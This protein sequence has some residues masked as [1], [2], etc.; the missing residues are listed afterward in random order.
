MLLGH[1]V[2]IVTEIERQ[3]GQVEQAPRNRRPPCCRPYNGPVGPSTRTDEVQG[4]LI[5]AGGDRR[6][7]SKNTLLPDRLDGV[8]GS[9]VCVLRLRSSSSSS[10]T[11]RRLAV[12]FVQMKTGNGD[13]TPGRGAGAPRQCQE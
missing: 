12:S 11:V 2:D 10:S 1:A 6:V 9:I 7:R 5:V 3:V 4:E 13:R 8:M